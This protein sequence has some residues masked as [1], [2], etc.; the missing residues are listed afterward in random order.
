MPALA[1]VISSILVSILTTLGWQKLIVKVAE[2]VLYYIANKIS[3]DLAKKLL[4]DMGDALKELE[5]PKP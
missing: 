2:D 5:Q 3:N 4:N 1:S